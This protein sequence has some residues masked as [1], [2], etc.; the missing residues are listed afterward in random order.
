MR[1]PARLIDWDAVG[2]H[3]EANIIQTLTIDFS[4]INSENER[5]QCFHASRLLRMECMPAVPYAMIGPILAIDKGL[6]RR[7][8]KWVI[9]HPNGPSPNGRPSILLQEQRDQLIEAI[10]QAYATGMPGTIADVNVYIE[11]HF[12]VHPTKQ[13][14][15]ELLKRDARVKSCRGIPTE[16][17]RTE[18]TSEEISDFFRR[19]RIRC[20]PIRMKRKCGTI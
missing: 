7:Q 20:S 6:V 12:R 10:S 5:D 15:H 3:V 14:I 11:E 18:V 16:D 1:A 17:R 13:M 4:F 8:F 19:A 9:V 2:K